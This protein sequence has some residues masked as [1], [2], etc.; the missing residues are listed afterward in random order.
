MREKS[1]KFFHCHYNFL[2]KKMLREFFKGHGMTV[3]VMYPYKCRK[4]TGATPEYFI[5]MMVVS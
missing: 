5:T 1:R 3:A 4:P 2:E